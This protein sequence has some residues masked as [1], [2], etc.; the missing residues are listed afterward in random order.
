MPG[1]VE[2]AAGAGGRD[3][4]NFALMLRRMYATWDGDVSC[5]AG[6]HRLVRISPFDPQRRRHTSFVRVT[7]DGDPGNTSGT[8]DDWVRTYYLHPHERVVDHLT[9]AETDKARRVLAGELDLILDRIKG[10]R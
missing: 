2:V 7:V 4:Q 10:G 6:V 9:G 3:S 8:V 5:E 1:K